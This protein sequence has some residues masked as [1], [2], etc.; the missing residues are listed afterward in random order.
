M[1]AA[2]VAGQRY[3]YAEKSRLL[4]RVLE[5]W[6]QVDDAAD[7]VGLDHLGLLESALTAAIGSGDNDR[8]LALARAALDEGELGRGA[9]ACGEAARAPGEAAAHLRQVRRRRR[10][11]RGVLPDPPDRGRA[12]QGA[13]ARGH[14]RHHDHYRPGGGG[15]IASEAATVA[16]DTHDLASQVSAAVTFGRVCSR[17]LSTEAGLAEMRRA[18]D[19]AQ[20][21]GDLPGRVRSMVNISDLLYDLGEY[22][23]SADVALHGI[24]DASRVGIG[25]TTGV[26]LLANRVR[27]CSRWGSGTRRTRSSTRWPGSTRPAAWRSCG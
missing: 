16:G 8:A 22:A 1:H 26:Y 17:E 19:A 20:A 7:R 15:Q 12:A 3:A 14:R 18:A 24:A 2:N 13:A 6:E 9:H 4:E 10:A 27:H 23:E 11:A 21:N 5:L 25:R